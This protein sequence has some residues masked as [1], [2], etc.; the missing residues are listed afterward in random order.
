MGAALTETQWALSP[1]GWRD[2]HLALSRLAPQCPDGRQLLHRDRLALGGLDPKQR[3]SLHEGEIGLDLPPAQHPHGGR[4]H[5]EDVPL[6]VVGHQSI[7]DGGDGGI[8]LRG[9]LRRL[10]RQLLPSHAGLCQPLVGLPHLGQQP[11]HLF[12]GSLPLAFC[13]PAF[14]HLG[15]EGAVHGQVEDGIHHDD[16]DAAV[17]ESSERVG[18]I[19]QEG[20]EA[21][22]DPELDHEYGP[23]HDQDQPS[24]PDGRVVLGGNAL[25]SVRREAIPPVLCLAVS[26]A[27]HSR[28]SSLPQPRC[29]E[30]GWQQTRQF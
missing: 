14:R 22:H 10:L 18:Q 16:Q 30:R 27:W 13:L 28:L 24:E 21:Q 29:E 5:V 26:L 1:G 9:P 3:Y 6:R 23:G 11:L 19:E 7:G 20:V 2:H 17:E 4:I 15:A 12:L 25:R 8:Q